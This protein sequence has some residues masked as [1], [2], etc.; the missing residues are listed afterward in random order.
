MTPQSVTTT[1]F[2]IDEGNLTNGMELAV[3][4]R[5]FTKRKSTG[6]AADGLQL[7]P[8]VSEASSRLDFQARPR[9]FIVYTPGSVR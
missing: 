3:L 8:D 6:N 1:S 7:V 2:Q 5:P 9:I 4:N